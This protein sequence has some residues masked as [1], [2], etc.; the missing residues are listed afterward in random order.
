MDYSSR[1]GQKTG[2][3]APLSSQEL[4]IAR[5][6]RLR[7][8]ALETVDL[9]NDPYIAKNQLGSY[10]CRLCLT[11]HSNESSYLAHTQGKKH[12]V[13]LARRAAAETEAT[14]PAPEP[15]HQTFKR[16]VKIG[17]P[18][19]RVTRVVHPETDVKGLLFEIDYPQIKSGLRPVKRVMSAYEQVVDLVDDSFQY[20]VVA[21]EPYQTIAFK[22]PNMEIDLETESGAF[23]YWDGCR[24]TVQLFLKEREA[25]PLPV[26]SQRPVIAM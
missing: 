10:E 9:K 14:A 26:V 19:Y 6:E 25:K 2:S 22:I 16:F 12:Q 4:A 21:A 18:G 1:P 15:K 23:E 17:R 3:G 13:N 24:Y 7:K 5:R 8:L 20:L 11:L